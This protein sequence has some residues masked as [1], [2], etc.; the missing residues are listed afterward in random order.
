[1]GKLYIQQEFSLRSERHPAQRAVVRAPFPLLGNSIRVPDRRRYAP[2]TSFRFHNPV[3]GPFPS[4]R[5][6][7]FR[8]KC[9]VIAPSEYPKS[10]S[11]LKMGK[12]GIG[13]ESA[14]GM[15]TKEF[16]GAA[17]AF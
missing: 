12:Q 9:P 17:L 5:V 1:M 7:P 8:P 10:L 6:Q 16:R 3:S 11:I 2:R 14:S 13:I 15:E 4:C